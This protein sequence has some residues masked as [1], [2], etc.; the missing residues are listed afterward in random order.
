MTSEQSFGYPSEWDDFARRNQ[1]FL[2]GF[3]KL[4]EALDTAF[5]RGVSAATLADRAILFL[6]RLSVE[7]FMELI[8]LAAN[9]Y[10]VGA[11]KLLRGLYER[12]VTAAYLEQHPEEVQHFLD[13]RFV[14]RYKA[15][16]AYVEG[17]TRDEKW[18]KKAR[19]V[20]LTG[21]H[22]W[23]KKDFVAMAKSTG[24]LGNLLA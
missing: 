9:G 11:M 24:E 2:A 3:L 22:T 18:V 4:K 8:C 7:D 1:A 17:G 19:D 5:V 21:Y 6:G 15:L 13:F 14:S 16:N 20:G 10:G 23:S 12:A